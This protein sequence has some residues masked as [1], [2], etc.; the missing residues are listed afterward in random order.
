MSV[1]A[2]TQPVSHV[3]S[4]SSVARQHVI[5]VIRS[6]KSSQSAVSSI[7]IRS[8]TKSA[9]IYTSHVSHS[10]SQHAR[11]TQIR[12]RQHVSHPQ[13]QV[14]SSSIIIRSN[15]TRQSVSS[16]HPQST[17]TSGSSDTS[18]SQQSVILRQHVIHVIR[19]HKSGSHNTSYAVVIIRHIS[20]PSASTSVSSQ[21]LQHQSPRRRK[22]IPPSAS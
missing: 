22:D 7:I 1:S 19:S 2:V 14:S 16:S 21:S 3:S 4:Q 15:T 5:H 11:H 13:S 6:H 9:V 18:V 8:H 20:H 17:R 12:S 10:Q